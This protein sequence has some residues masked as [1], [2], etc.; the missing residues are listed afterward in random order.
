MGKAFGIK[1]DVVKLVNS[2]RGRCHQKDYFI[3]KWKVRPSAD[4]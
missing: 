1:R 3:Y 2:L 4:F